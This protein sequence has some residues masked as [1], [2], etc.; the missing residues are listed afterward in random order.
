MF[1]VIQVTSC[2]YVWYYAPRMKD[3]QIQALLFALGMALLVWVAYIFGP[4][5]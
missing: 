2:V 3:W 1:R 5:K 4:F